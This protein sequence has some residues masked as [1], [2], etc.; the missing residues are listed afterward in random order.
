M[1]YNVLN[2][3]NGTFPLADVNNDINILEL[4]LEYE[5]YINICLSLFKWE[6]LPNNINPIFLEMTL[7]DNG[8]GMF[9]NDK[10]LGFMFV[11]CI[12]SDKLNYQNEAISYTANT[13]GYTKSFLKDEIV[14]VRNN[15]L[16]IPTSKMLLNYC[17]K[18]SEC[19]N[20]TRI[21]LQAQKTPILVVCD[22]KDLL[23]MKNIYEDY[24]GNIPVIFGDKN[25][26]FENLKVLKTDSPFVIDKISDYK[27]ILKNE[28]L[29]NLGIDNTNIDKKERLITDEV[30]SNNKE[31][32][33]NRNVM[34]NERKKACELINKKFN[35]NVSVSI[36]VNNEDKE[37]SE[38]E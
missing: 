18:I 23:T 25:L 15:P 14:L 6:N 24:K 8:K 28:L 7:I 12:E 26:N 31:I 38:S 17:L 16:E 10:E 36:N 4:Q 13:I 30:N 2:L 32:E 35:L 22:D 1:K 33:I 9:I 37:V 3:K 21:N 20:I 29:T 5:K 34:L 11:P 27:I 19:S